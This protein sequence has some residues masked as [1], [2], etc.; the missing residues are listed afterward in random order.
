MNG[1]K[2]LFALAAVLAALAG[3][4]IWLGFQL[5]KPAGKPLSTTPNCLQHHGAFCT[6]VAL[7]AISKQDIASFTSATGVFPSIV[8]YYQTFGKSFSLASAKQV[9][10]VGARPFIQLNPHQISMNA[11]VSG[12]YDKYINNYATAVK[13]FGHPIMLSFGHEMNG[14]WSS[15]SE[16]FT[17][18]SDFIAAWR[19]IHD[20]FVKDKV[21]NATWTW[22][23]SHTGIHQPKLWW[24]GNQYVDWIGIDGYLRPGQTFAGQYDKQ[25]KY[26]RKMVAPAHKPV[27]ISET[28]VAPGKN[29]VKQ[30]N[31][32]FKGAR[33]TRLVALIWFDVN[34]LAK[35]QLT[36]GSPATQAFRKN[37]DLPPLPASPQDT[38]S[39]RNTPS[40][41]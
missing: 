23:V 20:I 25:I 37:A 41:K 39:P 17:K 6:G 7:K 30:I 11:I 29:Q 27:F 35:W 16:P 9:A 8:E 38:P 4:G 2:K 19:H 33:E 36:S 10:I 21:K 3:G 13:K 40:H 34:K 18:P 5:I 12:Q 28:A 31:D 1:W 15:W 14:N 32:L 22:D 26:L 24:P